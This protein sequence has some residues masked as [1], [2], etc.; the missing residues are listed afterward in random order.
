MECKSS[1]YWTVGRFWN[2]DF[3]YVRKLQFVESEWDAL[4]FNL[5]QSKH[6]PNTIYYFRLQLETIILNFT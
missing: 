4:E 3:D 2:F 5:F 6:F 1:F